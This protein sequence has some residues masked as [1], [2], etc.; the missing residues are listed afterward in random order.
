MRPLFYI[1]LIILFSSCQQEKKNA[2]NFEFYPNTLDS[3]DFKT[4]FIKERTAITKLYNLPTLTSGTN[5]SLVIRFWPW[6]A[7]QPW[8]NMFEFRLDSIEW[9]GYHYCSYTYPNQDGRIIHI[10]GHE[11]L[12][13]SVFIIKQIKPKCGWD[14]LYDSPNYFQLTS[15]P[16]QTLINGFESKL[17]MD[18]DAVEFEI[19]TK[20]SYRWIGYSNPSSYSYKECHQIEELVNMFRR[21]FGDD[22][23]WPIK[24]N[25]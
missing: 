21:Q 8:S 2:S 16:T 13:D 15:I 22:Y 17:I 6:E 18:G 1:L 19:A 4:K 11:K 25:K 14:K 7:F 20:N 3:T 12:G 5:D 9:R 24:R 23:Y 10:D